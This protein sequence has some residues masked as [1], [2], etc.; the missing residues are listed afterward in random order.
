MGG[1]HFGDFLTASRASCGGEVEEAEEEEGGEDV[2]EPV[3]FAEVA[4]GQVEDGPGDD[5]EAEAVGDGASERD[6][7]EGEERGQAF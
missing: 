3:F 4:G 2:E 1:R 7:D 5:A 6:E